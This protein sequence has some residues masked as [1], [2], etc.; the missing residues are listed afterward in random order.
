[1]HCLAKPLLISKMPCVY[2]FVCEMCC[3]GVSCDDYLIIYAFVSLYIMDV[4]ML[5][6]YNST[7]SIL[8]Y[9]LV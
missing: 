2:Y 6:V 1:M 3:L 9:L 4:E 8:L 7:K 5:T